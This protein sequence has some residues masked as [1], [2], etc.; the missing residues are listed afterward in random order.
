MLSIPFL[1]HGQAAAKHTVNKTLQ[2]TV[3]PNGQC[4]LLIAVYPCRHYC[5]GD[6]TSGVP[7]AIKTHIINDRQS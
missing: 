6:S 1:V 7:Y 5:H 2:I 4:D 3:A